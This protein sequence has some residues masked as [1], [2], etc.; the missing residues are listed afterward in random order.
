VGRHMHDAADALWM[1]KTAYLAD[2]LCSQE[3]IYT[4][5]TIFIGHNPYLVRTIHI[6][7]I[8]VKPMHMTHARC[9]AL[10]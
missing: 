9:S 3:K 10:S 1:Y 6:Y 2:L 7:L 5:L 8:S 4:R